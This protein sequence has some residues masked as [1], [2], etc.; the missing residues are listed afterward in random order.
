MATILAAAFICFAV[1]VIILFLP[2]GLED[3]M[4]G[5]VSKFH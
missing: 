2:S 3:G 4:F 1:G 5:L